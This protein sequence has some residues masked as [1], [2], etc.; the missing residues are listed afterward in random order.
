[1]CIVPIT[2]K[3]TKNN[4]KLK[5]IYVVIQKSKNIKMITIKNLI[6][7]QKFCFVK[8]TRNSM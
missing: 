1:M 8:V 3:E 6:T 2:I 7:F 4:A 5:N